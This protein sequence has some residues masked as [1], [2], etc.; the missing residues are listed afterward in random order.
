MT[1][2]HPL[3]RHQQG[4]IEW[5]HDVKRGL[6]ANEPGL[7][8]SRSAIEAFDGGRNLIIAP[9]LVVTG[10]TWDDEL[11]KWSQDPSKWTV[12]TYSMLNERKP[13]GRGSGTKPV[14]KLRE[15]WRGKWD[16]LVIDEAH[17]VKGRQTSWTWASEEIAKS[18]SSVLLM[19]GT[20]I[21]NWAHELFTL[22][23]IIY[24][25]ESKPGQKFGSF[26]RWAKE[27]FDTSPTRFSQGMPVAGEMLNCT[28]ACFRRPTSDPCVHYR[29]FTEENL[30]PHFRRI[31]REEALDLPPLTTQIVHTDLDATARKMYRELKKDFITEYDGEEVVAWSQGAA[32]VLLDKVTTS[33]WLLTKKGEPR[34]GKL[35][36]LAFDLESRSRP[37]LVL[38]HY[39]DT[40]EAC[41]AVARKAGAT[42]GVVHGGI[43]RSDQGAAVRAFKEGR[44]DVLVGSLETL[45]EGLTLTVADMAIFVEMSYKPSRNEQARFRVHRMGQTRPVTIREYVTRKTVDEHKREL[46][47]TK[48]DRQM[49]VMKAHE[50]A[51][52]L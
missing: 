21:P 46:L 4:D 52:L 11:E 48:T 1:D 45:A 41:A 38:A 7:G 18:S 50:L 49:R 33:P 27:W 44:L 26:W 3:L 51:A 35:D 42:A 19:T 20:P 39:R 12:A 9:N 17:Y 37:T 25:G 31:L 14:S 15:P 5:I 36:T 22:L 8:K 23:K 32:N 47:A 30:G 29:R 43:S 34:G 40:V 10:G 2:P 13:T 6:L 24:P 16:A 28:E